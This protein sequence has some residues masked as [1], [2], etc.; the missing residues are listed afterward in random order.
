[1]RAI[2]VLR[3][4]VPGIRAFSERSSSV[5]PT[6]CTPGRVGTAGTAGTAGMAGIAVRGLG[7]G[8]DGLEEDRVWLDFHREKDED[9]DG[10]AP[11]DVARDRV[12]VGRFSAFSYSI[13][14]SGTSAESG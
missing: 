5:S 4:M 3:K 14:V 1:M 9:G 7:G 12:V 13:I 6:A 10:R 11:P 2:E 8:L